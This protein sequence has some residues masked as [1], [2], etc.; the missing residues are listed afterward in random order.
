M[1]VVIKK[2]IEAWRPDRKVPSPGYKCGSITQTKVE[3][4]EIG[5]SG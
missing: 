2:E 1:A 5:L 4:A 3:R